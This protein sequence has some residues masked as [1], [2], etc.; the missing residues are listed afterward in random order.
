[1]LARVGH[2]LHNRARD[3]PT[4]DQHSWKAKARQLAQKYD[5]S[6]VDA[7]AA[8][9]LLFPLCESRPQKNVEKF[10]ANSPCMELDMSKLKKKLPSNAFSPPTRLHSATAAEG[11]ELPSPGSKPR[12]GKRQPRGV[13]EQPPSEYPYAYL[14]IGADRKPVSSNAH[15]FILFA[16]RG[17]PPLCESLTTQDQLDGWLSKLHAMHLCHNP[18]CMNFLHLRWGLA[19]DNYHG[20]GTETSQPGKH[21]YESVKALEIPFPAH[22][23]NASFHAL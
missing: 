17:L 1:M 7:E 12:R 23:L 4:T 9:W 2:Y 5:I 21:R 22:A 6:D 11:S 10:L 3:V 14:G 18:K 19:A 16:C 20:S 8:M 13:Y 15:R